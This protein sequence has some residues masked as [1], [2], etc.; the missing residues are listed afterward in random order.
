[1]NFQIHPE[2]QGPEGRREGFDGQV[3]IEHLD[4]GRLARVRAT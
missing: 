1:M 3:A 4:S 2:D